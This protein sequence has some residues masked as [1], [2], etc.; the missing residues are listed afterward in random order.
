MIKQP[1]FRFLQIGLCTCA[2][3]SAT[4]DITLAQVTSDN[5]VNTKVN[6]NGSVAEITGGTTRGDN[7]FHSFREFSVRTGNEAFFNNWALC[8]RRN[9]SF[10]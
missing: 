3:L 5:T 9:R 10:D 7:L 1:I 4:S 8:Y 6:Q 2:Y